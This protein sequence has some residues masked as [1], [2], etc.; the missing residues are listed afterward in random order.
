VRVITEFP[1]DPEPVI[2]KYKGKKAVLGWNPGDEPARRGITPEQMFTRYDRI[3][4]L[5]PDHL[6]YTVICVPSQYVRYAAGTDV[7]APDPYPVPRHPIDVVYGSVKQAKT[8]S[9]RV[10]TALWAVIQAFGGQRYD[11][12][13]DWPRC[14]DARE[15]R[16]M[17]YLA[18]MAGARG[19]IYYT[20]CDNHFDILLEPGLLEAAKTFPA[21]LRDLIPFVLDGK[22]EILAE[23]A[24]GVY[25]TAWTLGS[26]R[27]LVAVNTR[28]KEAD[29]KL[30]F[31]GGQVLY[32]APRDLRME[33]GRV[34]F[35]IPPL[36]RVVLTQGTPND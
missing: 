31:A 25:A 5:D 10:D 7:L 1:G 9:L 13:G 21:E 29:V 30:P 15:F 18:L 26:E 33:D 17:S 16:A 3:K 14:P 4:Q 2:E 20:Y 24:D 6:A 8:E 19:I 23:D 22:S 32:G 35:T 12:S 11:K 34:H 36:E 28:E 27:R